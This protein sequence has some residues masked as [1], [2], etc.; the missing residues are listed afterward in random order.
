MKAD[1]YS[2][3]Q[4]HD[5]LKT[6]WEAL[7]AELTEAFEDPTIREEWKSNFKAYKWDEENVS[8]QTYC[9]KVQRYVDTYDT[10]LIGTA[11]GRQQQ[12]YTRFLYGLTDEYMEYVRLSMPPKSMDINKA[13]DL[14]I[15]YQNVKKAKATS[16]STKTKT[17][18]GASVTFQDPTL[19]T[20]VTQNSTD[21]NRINNKLDK[22]LKFQMAASKGNTE[23]SHQSKS[24]SQSPH[25]SDDRSQ[26][27]MKRFLKN[28]KF[29]G[30]GGFKRNNFQNK[31]KFKKP[32]TQ[33][34]NKAEQG[35]EEALGLETEVE[36]EA[37][38]NDSV[39]LYDELCNKAELDNFL[40]FCAVKDSVSG[41]N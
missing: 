6:N 23:E 35:Q 37:D 11:G 7:R 12:Y 5:H 13:L 4:R 38:V 33:Q 30:R 19:P 15:R 26:D 24:T 32:D 10:Q 40:A 8:L 14:C 27:R 18:V 36:S 22:I 9:A 39:M 25:R 34:G 21:I 2:I 28:S 16:S 3:W 1:A 41:E 17:E 20:R 29:S 31:S